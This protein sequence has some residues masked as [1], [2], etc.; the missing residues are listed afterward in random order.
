MKRAALV[1]ALALA[2]TGC[3]SSPA[4][5]EE[6]PTTTPAAEEE[7]PTPTPTAEADALVLCE[8]MSQKLFEYPDY[9]LA[10][11]NGEFDQATHDDYYAWAEEMKAVAPADA[12]VPLAKFTDPI[13]QVQEVVEVGGG[14]LTF[15]TDDYKAGNLEIMEYCVDAGFK[16]DN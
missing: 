14:S 7:K 15:S 3:A 9:V 1:V 5:E 2:L 10:I 16:V 11:A 4:A 12:N 6:G 13:Y 8:L